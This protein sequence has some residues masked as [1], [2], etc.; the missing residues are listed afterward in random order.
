[1]EK[2]ATEGLSISFLIVQEIQD[3][4]TKKLCQQYLNEE[5][6]FPK[7]IEKGLFT[8]AAID[9]VDY[10]PSSTTAKYSFHGS[11]YSVPKE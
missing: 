4:I 7:N 11:I 6:V 9:N 8:V 5:I 1:M 10:D 3:N 2:L